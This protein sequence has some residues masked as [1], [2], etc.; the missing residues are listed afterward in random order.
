MTRVT[1][2]RSSTIGVDQIDSFVDYQTRMVARSKEIAR[3]AQEMVNKSNSEPE[4]LGQLS[5]DLTKN[6]A[7]LANDSIGAASSTSNVDV[8]TRI[9]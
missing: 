3:L 9:R 7:Q 2:N 4:K 8:S 1:D 6:Y 5:V